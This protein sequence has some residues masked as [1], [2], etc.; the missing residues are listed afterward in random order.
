MNKRDL[1]GLIVSI[2]GIMMIIVF[3]GG[4]LF[5]IGKSPGFGRFQILGCLA[6]VMTI[7]AGVLL[8][9][10][11]RQKLSSRKAAIALL[12]GGALLLLAASFADPLGVGSYPEFGL[13]QI[14]GVLLGAFAMIFAGLQ[15]RNKTMS[16]PDQV[17]NQS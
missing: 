6:G 13:V 10:Q 8:N 4:D 7:L 2:A 5:H 17:D 11:Q 12:A 14:A 3:A 16:E 9:P 15:L 1:P